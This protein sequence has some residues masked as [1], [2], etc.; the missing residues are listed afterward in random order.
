[1]LDGVAPGEFAHEDARQALLILELKESMDAGAAE[2][3]VR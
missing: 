3:A 2:V 1:M